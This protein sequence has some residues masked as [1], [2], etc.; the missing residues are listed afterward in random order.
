MIFAPRWSQTRRVIASPYIVLPVLV[1]TVVWGFYV[2]F[3]H[4]PA[5]GLIELLGNF[6]SPTGITGLMGVPER[7]MVVWVHLLVFDL[8]AGRW[9]YLDSRE[10]DYNVWWVSP[11]LLLTMNAAPFGFLIYLLVRRRK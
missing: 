9:I 10:R 7:A 1:V 6:V 11:L 3:S 4:P 2:W 8:F 5:G